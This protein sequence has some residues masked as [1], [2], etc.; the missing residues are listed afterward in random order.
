MLVP[1]YD[2]TWKIVVIHKYL[3]TAHL[4]GHSK[5]EGR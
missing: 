1:I 5:R 4:S 2:P 3:I